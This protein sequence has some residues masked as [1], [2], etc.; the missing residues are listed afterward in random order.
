MALNKMQWTEV[1]FTYLAPI[2]LYINHKAKFKI[3]HIQIL[4]FFILTCR[5]T[6]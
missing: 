5:V 3:M 2:L 4:F 1:H 6:C